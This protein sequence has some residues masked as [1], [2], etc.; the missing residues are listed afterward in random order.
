MDVMFVLWS[1]DVACSKYR[2]CLAKAY[3]D[4]TKTYYSINRQ[5]LWKPLQLYVVH[6]KLIALLKD[7]Y[8][9][10]FATVWMDRALDARFLDIAGV[11]QMIWF[12]LRMI[13]LAVMMKVMD[14]IASKFGMMINA[15][16]T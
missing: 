16:K 11:M 13:R 7:L 3:T 15:S 1:I 8:T 5:A 6:L 9:C 4:F 10:T 2:A 14:V 12:C